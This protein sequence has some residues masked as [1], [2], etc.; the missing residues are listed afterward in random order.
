MKRRRISILIVFLMSVLLLGIAPT[1]SFVNAQPNKADGSSSFPQEQQQVLTPQ[2]SRNLGYLNTRAAGKRI[3]R[4]IYSKR[5]E[6]S[7][8]FQASDGSYIL[9][10]TS[11]PQ[12]YQDENGNWQDIDTSLVEGANVKN[13]DSPL[14]NQTP[15]EI[16]RMIKESR[17]NPTFQPPSDF[18]ALRVP[19]HATIPKLYSKGYTIGKGSDR[20]TL[21]PVDAE[22][23]KGVL[24]DTKDTMIY[25]EAWKQTDVEL[26]V[27]SSGIKETIVLNSPAAPTTFRFEVMGQLTDDF[28]SGQLFIHPAWLEDA[29]GV[30][31]DVVQTIQRKGGKTFLELTPD[32]A[33][34]TFPI[35][36]DPTVTGSNTSLSPPGTSSS[37]PM[38]RIYVDVPDVD[39]TY[40]TS[41]RFEKFPAY[42]DTAKKSDVF[43]TQ[44][45][46]GNSP[47]CYVPCAYPRPG[48][49]GRNVVFV[50]TTGTIENNRE[51]YELTGDQLRQRTGYSLAGYT[52]P[53]YGGAFY[54]SNAA[55]VDQVWMYIT[56]QE[57][58]APLNAAVISSDIPDQMEAGHSYP[59]SITLQNTG[60]QSWTGPHVQL[61]AIASKNPFALNKVDVPVGTVIHTNEQYT[62]HFTMSIPFDPGSLGTKTSDWQLVSD[63]VTGFGQVF[64]KTI[65]VN[66]DSEPTVDEI[67][68]HIDQ[69]NHQIDLYATNVWRLSGVPGVEFHIYPYGYLSYDYGPERKIATGQLENNIWRASFPFSGN[70]KPNTLYVMEVFVTGVKDRDGFDTR[71][72]VGKKIINVSPATINYFYDKNGRMNFIQFPNGA[73]MRYQYDAN[74]NFINKARVDGY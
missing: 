2:A 21:I 48:A 64:S 57:P 23:A 29:A 72:P 41:I 67:G 59:V 17:K 51:V 10:M 7:K 62:F 43:I 39:Q 42:T 47:P 53:I 34:L 73:L 58:P 35:K 12:H 18:Y 11:N 74:G 38:N 65:T 56:Y 44:Q 6:N 27:L 28:L 22:A 25:H 4:E 49:D 8:L 69:S 33:G 3:A 32:V 68:Y 36:I 1:A 30:Q 66:D 60:G 14:S 70:M 15:A 71:M 46:Y 45:E 20:L 54:A 55:R 31:R 50:G 13:L 61:G 19:F 37:P 24:A 26:T 9:A 63:N 40:V 16:K 52:G 5:T